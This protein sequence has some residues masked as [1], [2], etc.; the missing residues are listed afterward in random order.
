MHSK[1]KPVRLVLARPTQTNDFER[2]QFTLD[3]LELT[4]LLVLDSSHMFEVLPFTQCAKAGTK[5][6]K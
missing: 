6:L 1:D 2:D 5:I 4:L 3:S